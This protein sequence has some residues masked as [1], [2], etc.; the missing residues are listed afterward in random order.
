MDAFVNR[1]VSFTI[2]WGLIAVGIHL[3]AK[4][5]GGSR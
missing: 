5:Y 3:L 1:V 4:L 2:A